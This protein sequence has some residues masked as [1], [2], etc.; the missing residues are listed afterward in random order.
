MCFEVL[1]SRLCRTRSE[2]TDK[3]P[4]GKSILV[5]FQKYHQ[6][7]SNSPKQCCETGFY[8]HK[9]SEHRDPGLEEIILIHGCK[10]LISW[11]L[12]FVHVLKSQDHCLR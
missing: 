7:A 8:H 10:V 4:C 6:N 11:V 9:C 12:R 3:L 2:I 5:F 1:N